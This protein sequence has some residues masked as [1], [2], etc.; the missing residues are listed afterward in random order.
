MR[1]MIVGAMA[2]LLMLA[3]CTSYYMVTEP[4]GAG[5]A[6]YTTRVEE[7][8]TGSV[9]FKDMRTGSKVTM[10]TSEVWQITVAELPPELQPRKD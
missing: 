8:P 10:A 7:L 1:T 6:Y 4:G 2:G 9:R 5:K 3:G